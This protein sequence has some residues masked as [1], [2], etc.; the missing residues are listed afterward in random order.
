MNNVSRE[1]LAAR[2]K[3]WRGDVSQVRAAGLLGIPART[4]EGIEQ[5]R[6]FRY[7]QML[8]LAMQAINFEGQN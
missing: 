7:E 2:L 3:A 8:I 5:G 6:P 1:T 4:L